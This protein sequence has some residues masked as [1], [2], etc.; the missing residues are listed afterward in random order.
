MKD[1]FI[2]TSKT[3]HS[4]TMTAR[5]DKE[6]NDKLKK[7]DFKSNRS[8]NELINMSLRYTFQNIEFT[9]NIEK[10]LVI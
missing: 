3:E 7:L 8:R 10:Q 1:K 9:E 2:V 5:I 4:V 6:L